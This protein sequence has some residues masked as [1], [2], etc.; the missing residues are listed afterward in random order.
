MAS[1]PLGRFLVWILCITLLLISGGEPALG[2]GTHPYEPDI[3]CQGP[4]GNRDDCFQQC[5]NMG[6]NN[7]GC[8]FGFNGSPVHDFI[9]CCKRNTVD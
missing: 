1:A 7:G 3:E 6:F 4:C 2:W 8:C 5:K 9:C